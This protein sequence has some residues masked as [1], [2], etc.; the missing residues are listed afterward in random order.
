MSRSCDTTIRP[1]SNRPHFISTDNE[2][3]KCEPRKWRKLT[4]RGTEE[5][6]RLARMT[7]ITVWR[8]VGFEAVRRKP[9][10]RPCMQSKPTVADKGASTER[11]LQ[12]TS[13][14]T[15]RE[16]AVGR[17]LK[18]A[19]QALI[20]CCTM[21]TAQRCIADNRKTD[22]TGGRQGEG[23][24]HRGTQ[25]HKRAPADSHYRRHIR[26]GVWRWRASFFP[27]S[28]SNKL[29]KGCMIAKVLKRDLCM[30]FPI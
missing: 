5:E 11:A 29:L 27:S 7:H 13:G 21:K 22:G 16:V 19:T 24:R 8:H 4:Y 6:Y 17:N 18:M 28:N 12:D 15:D 20:S 2:M 3:T 9:S 30:Y 26:H 14:Q 25:E 10:I 1:S 23:T